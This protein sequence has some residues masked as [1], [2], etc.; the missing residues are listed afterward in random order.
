MKYDI[1]ARRKPIFPIAIVLDP[2]FK[3]GHIPHGEQKFVMETLPNMLEL[4]HSIQASTSTPIDDVL[5]SLSH[6]HSKVMMQFMEQQSNRCTI[7]EEKSAE[8]ELEEYLREPCINCLHDDSLQWWCKIGSNKYTCILVFS[9]EFL[10]ICAL[11][12]PSKCLF[13]YK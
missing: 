2:R 3:L 4:V 13:F 9:K 5:A 7:V 12:S 6:K 8:S 11:S 1:Q 10:S